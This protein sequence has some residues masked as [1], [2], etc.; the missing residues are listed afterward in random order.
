M[1]KWVKIS[2]LVFFMLTCQVSAVASQGPIVRAILFYSPT[3]PH[4]HTVITEV[5]PP[6]LQIY[7][8]EPQ[9]LYI[10]PTPE[11][12]PV[13]PPLIG[14]FGESLEILYV[15]IYTELGQGLYESAFE[16]LNIPS[17]LR[18]VPIMVVDDRYLVGGN[19]IPEQLP[20]IIEE[21]LASGGIDWVDLSGLSSAIEALIPAPT[22][23]PPTEDATQEVIESPVPT[24]GVTDVTP[25]PISS[26]TATVTPPNQG[27]ENPTDSL[28]LNEISIL[29]RI[30]LDLEG[31]ILAIVVLVGMVISI[32]M[33]SSR[34]IFPDDIVKKQELSWLIPVLCII[35][36]G[37]AT[38]LTYVEA[39]GTEAVCGPV[40]D[41]NTVQESK[42]AILFG[43]LPV[44][45]LGLLG[46]AGI[47]LAW[48]V[49]KFGKE[50]W[51]YWA[52]VALVGMSLFGT[53]FSIYLTFLEPFVIGATCMWC[54]TS[55][56]IMT[57]LLWLTA[58][59]GSEA[60]GRLRGME[61]G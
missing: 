23:P 3:C 36:I 49:A 24:E 40:G 12:E 47:I 33:V 7:G 37:V 14:I 18:V 9:V 19:E 51:I 42:Y 61:E 34:L 10:P 8:G 57:L 53:L 32:A 11:E 54:V 56:V 41:C 29:E 2:I 4:C 50:P 39:S 28:I 1:R 16:V 48:L 60:I 13:G 22:E 45:A 20:S 25:S 44:G 5:L 43:I 30:K 17:E 26:N 31:N 15:N 59:P 58:G 55:A 46:Y 52:N 27:I 21:G 38:Y 35:G 6:L